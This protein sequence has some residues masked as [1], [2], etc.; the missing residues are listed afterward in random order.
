MD[1]NKICYNIKRLLETGNFSFQNENR[2]E[3][4]GIMLTKCD[5]MF[6]QKV[7][8][9]LAIC[10]LL[11]DKYSQCDD[12]K[13]RFD[14]L[15]QLMIYQKHDIGAHNKIIQNMLQLDI[16]NINIDDV[17][18]EK[19]INL[20]Q[21][22]DLMKK[23]I[24]AFMAMRKA[25]NIENNGF[26]DFGE[27]LYYLDNV[28]YMKILLDYLSNTSDNLFKDPLLA[29]NNWTVQKVGEYVAKV[30]SENK[31]LEEYIKQNE[32][33][34]YLC[35]KY[36]FNWKSLPELTRD[37]IISLFKKCMVPNYNDPY[38]CSHGP[39]DDINPREWAFYYS[40]I[41]IYGY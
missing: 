2:K 3:R 23:D 8:D 38:E 14:G 26:I 20:L 15:R 19:L 36:G 27:P 33:D 12:D 5:K 22:N 24:E 29:G 40:N 25:L 32:N 37:E 1:Y 6:Q 16:I 13:T 35:I 21:S 39:P 41:H 28:N 4:H 31:N 7:G 10:L 18:I 30:T 9:I 17:F 11:D 34:V